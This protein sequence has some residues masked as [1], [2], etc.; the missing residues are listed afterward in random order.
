MA[1][2]LLFIACALFPVVAFPLVWMGTTWLV[3]R[4]L[5]QDAPTAQPTA[6]IA[7]QPAWGEGLRAA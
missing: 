1:T 3:R 4:W 5:A 2:T 7:I 6:T